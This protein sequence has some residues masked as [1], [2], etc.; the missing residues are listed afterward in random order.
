MKP[1]AEPVEN[2]EQPSEASVLLIPVLLPSM[3][4][5]G[6]ERE[7]RRSIRKVKGSSAAWDVQFKAIFRE[8][9]AFDRVL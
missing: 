8:K 5:N 4:L 7:L 6:L 9:E 3:A 1:T 2:R